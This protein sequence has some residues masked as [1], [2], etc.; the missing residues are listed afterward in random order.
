M[1][2]LDHTREVL[3]R[4]PGLK[5]GFVIYR[6]TYESDSEW[7]RFMDLLNTRVRLNLEEEGGLD[8]LDRLD[9]CVQDD[10]DVLNAATPYQVRTEFANWIQ[11]CGEEDDFFGTPRF[12]ACA[13]VGQLEL[14][15]MLKGPPAEEFD[16]Y[17]AGFLTLVSLDEDEDYQDVGLSYLVPRIYA[18][19]AGPGWENIVVDGVAIP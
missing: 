8:L 7:A 13:M 1:S 19:L 14:E 18:L 9:W 3:E 6:C 11:E 2:D 16:A 12:Q 5:W 17:G 15:L 10:R 4:N